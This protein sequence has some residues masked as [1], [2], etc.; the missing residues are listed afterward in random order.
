[1]CGDFLSILTVETASSVTCSLK[2]PSGGHSTHANT[3]NG[4]CLWHIAHRID[5]KTAFQITVELPNVDTVD[6][7]INKTQRVTIV[8]LFIHQRVFVSTH[9]RLIIT[10]QNSWCV[11]WLTVSD[12]PTAHFRIQ[13]CHGTACDLCSNDIIVQLAKRWQ[14]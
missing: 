4:C 9:S 8:K 2:E 13:S 11:H 7:K 1:M 14:L 10:N 6:I 3:Y 5:P 12:C